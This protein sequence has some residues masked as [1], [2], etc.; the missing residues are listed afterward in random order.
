MNLARLEKNGPYWRGV[1]Q[2]RHGTIRRGLGS[3]TKAQAARRLREMTPAQMGPGVLLKAYARQYLAQRESELAESTHNGHRYAL[4]SLGRYLG[5][6]VKLREISPIVARGFNRS[7]ADAAINTR[8]KTIRYLRTVWQHAVDD[9]VVTENPWSKVPS[10]HVATDRSNVYVEKQDAI[11]V[12]CGDHH[13][14]MLMTLTRFCGLRL[15]EAQRCLWA[16]IDIEGKLLT[17][18]HDG[19][20]TTKRRRRTVPLSKAAIALLVP[21][22]GSEP[23]DHGV[24]G[25]RHPHRTLADRNSGRWNFQDCRASLETDWTSNPSNHFADVAQWLGHSPTVALL[26]YH[27]GRTELNEDE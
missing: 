7:M 21:P 27:R 20:H 26:H 6:A 4:Q 9:G 12:T 13:W 24:E 17:V 3:G 14:L 25:L 5:A 10:S 23:D 11:G 16:D 22:E 19:R 18:R 8:R 1:I 2:T 15:G